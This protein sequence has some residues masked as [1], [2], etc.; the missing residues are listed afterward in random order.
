MTPTRVREC[1]VVFD[2]AD[3]LK[4]LLDTNQDIS[5]LQAARVPAVAEG[6]IDAGRVLCRMRLP[7]REQVGEA[8]ERISSAPSVDRTICL[9]SGRP[10]SS[11]LGRQIAIPAG[12]MS[13]A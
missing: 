8:V 4:A 9:V 10:Q 6:T 1:V 3:D 7:G 11:E 12:F 13:E 2:L 5:Q